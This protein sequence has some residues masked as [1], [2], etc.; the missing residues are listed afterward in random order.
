MK[1]GWISSAQGGTKCQ[2]NTFFTPS[3]W[4]PQALI[5]KIEPL[6]PSR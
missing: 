4:S 3:E 1:K 5:W 6:V 2:L